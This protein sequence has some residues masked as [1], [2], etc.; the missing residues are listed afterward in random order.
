MATLRSISDEINFKSKTASRDKV[1]YYVM[2]KGQPVE[3]I[4]MINIYA[5]NIRIPE[6]ITQ[7]RRGLKGEIDSYGKIGFGQDVA[8]E[9][10]LYT[11]DGNVSCYSFMKNSREVPQNI[12]VELIYDPATPLLVV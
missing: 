9:G 3:N 10:P 11:V 6:Y 7:T 5:P 1:G 2:M 4:T 8:E 12:K